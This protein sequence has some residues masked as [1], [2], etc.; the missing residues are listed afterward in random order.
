MSI[1]VHST[2][3]KT[4][5]RR[6]IMVDV[7]KRRAAKY[8]F[9]R[10]VV[11]FHIPILI[12]A[13]LLLIPC[14]I[15]YIHTRVNY[16]LLTY[17]P[18]D[19]ET[20]QGQNILMDDF[21]KGAFSIVVVEGMDDQDVAN[22]KSEIEQVPHVDTVLWG[23]ELTTSNIPSEVI[24]SEYN[25][26]IN[27]GDAQM[28]AVFF[29]TSTSSDDTLSAIEQIRGLSDQQVYVSGMSALVTDL[30]NLAEREEPVYVGVAVLGAVIALL[31]LTDSWLIPFI[32]LASIG[33]AIMWNLG[34]NYF[35]GDIS[36]I[37]KALAAVLQLA[38]TMDYS[39][40]LWHAFTEQRENYPGDNDQAMTVAIGDTLTAIVSSAL[41]AS[42]GF[43]ALCFMSYTLGSDL[44]IVMAKG[45]LLGLLGSVTTLP[46]LILIFDK[47]LEK[48]RHR[49]LIPSAKRLCTSVTKNYWVYLLI[50][51]IVLIP[52]AYGYANKP[53]YYN[54]TNILTGGDIS[55][56]NPDDLKFYTANT[57]VEDDFNVA[58]TEMVLCK[59]DMSHADA[60]EMLSRIDDVDG[61]QYALGYDSLVGGNIP[62]EAVPQE[63]KDAL[64]S[65]D[66]QLILINSSYEVSSDE[67]NAQIDEINTII[68]EY[69]SD[70]MLIGE[71][72]ATKDLISVTDTDF[73]VVDWVAIISI[74]LI[75]LIVFKSI[76]LPAILV[77]VIEFAI[78]INLGLPFYM[79]DPM[80]FL[81]P[82]CIS[83]IQLGSTVNYAI[84]MTTRYRKERY[85]G[86]GKK[87]AVTIAMTTSLPSI[88][89]SAV[90]FFAATF[91]VALYSN[92]SL[93]SSMCTLM[94]R[95]AIIS[96]L[97]VLFILPA[98]FMLLDNVIIH[99]SRYFR[100]EIEEAKHH[101]NFLKRQ[102]ESA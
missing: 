59:A 44:G 95:G 43:L 72:P 58:T 81:A 88:V 18:S 50:F 42:A 97:S 32:F 5:K 84:L 25:D 10:F 19:M 38:V 101:K 24:P 12:I 26:K 80:P 55:K 46:A 70:S 51:V 27:S 56:M 93:I 4:R 96:M 76:S 15:G 6:G 29:D 37:T 22:L 71:A 65:G 64:K 53:V 86:E 87:S 7:H 16:D 63:A 79:D 47:A 34:S 62:D 90:S 1:F 73:K 91:G 75:L 83:T 82:V 35:M 36:Y 14:T 98:F 40:F 28:L 52:A 31:A 66:Y 92:V 3:W 11:R 85:D 8:G 57:K 49:T 23:D 60:K 41:T 13:L 78:M 39:I 20:V 2:Y 61:V 9:G 54:F 30:K 77:F 21:G 74:I 69:D 94:A 48:T 33:I 102:E 68:K 99:T 67:C 100:P 17:L 45:C 89:T